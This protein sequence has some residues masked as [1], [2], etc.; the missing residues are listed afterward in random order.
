MGSMC[1]SEDLSRSSLQTRN[2]HI[3]TKPTDLGRGGGGG[4]TPKRGQV[5]DTGGIWRSLTRPRCFER[6]PAIFLVENISC[7]IE[8]YAIIW[9]EQ[10]VPESHHEEN[11]AI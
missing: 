5:E 1:V 8:L 11:K 7:S 9:G 4:I 6:I 2:S 3:V 10:E